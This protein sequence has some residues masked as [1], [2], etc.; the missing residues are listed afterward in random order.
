MVGEDNTKKT[1][2]RSKS[3]EEVMRE[4]QRLDRYGYKR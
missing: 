4:R 1:G 2:S 3:I